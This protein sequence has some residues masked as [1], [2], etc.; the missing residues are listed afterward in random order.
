MLDADNMLSHEAATE[1]NQCADQST[2]D[3]PLY[4]EMEVGEL[5]LNCKVQN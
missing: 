2:R 4:T 3:C 5:I 1:E